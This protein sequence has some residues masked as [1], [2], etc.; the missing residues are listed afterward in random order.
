M[1]LPLSASALVMLGVGAVLVGAS[2]LVVVAVRKRKSA[3]GATR[4]PPD[5]RMA[6]AAS[7]P[8]AP[9]PDVAPPAAPQA[10]AAPA[11][12]A[13]VV[14][15]Q[16]EPVREIAEQ[17]QVP[18]PQPEP[19]VR[20]V[21]AAATPRAAEVSARVEPPREPDAGA[22]VPPPTP[23]GGV[24]VAAQRHP[25][26][27][28]G[29][30]VAAA[31]AQAFAMR[32]AASRGGT[33]RPAD[34]PEGPT[35][36][37]DPAA[38][39]DPDGRGLGA[40]AD[41][42]Q[43]SDHGPEGNGK[44][45]Q[46]W[47]VPESASDAQRPSQAVTAAPLAGGWTPPPA[48]ATG[49]G[50]EQQKD[51]PGWAAHEADALGLAAAGQVPRGDG[52]RDQE[53]ADRPQ[54]E[55][56]GAASERQDEPGWVAPAA[57]ALG[58]AAA[59]LAF[60]GDGSS[61]RAEREGATPGQDG[62]GAAGPDAAGQEP[63]GDG[64]PEQ[65]EQQDEPGWLAPPAGALGSA[66]AGHA[67]RGH[68]S[69]EQE[70]TTRGQDGAGPAALGGDG[71]PEQTD[72]GQSD[73]PQAEPEAAAPEQT[74][75]GSI[76]PAGGALGLAAAGQALHGY[77][78]PEQ[79]EQQDKPGWVAPAAGALGLAA[80]GHA[81]HGRGTPEPGDEQAISAPA[82]REEA[83]AEEA[84][85]PTPRPGTE[86]VAAEEQPLDAR[87]RLLAVLLDDPERAVGATVELESCLRELDRL[88]DAVRTGRTAL[89]DV[90][91][92]LVSAGL[93]PEQLARLAR[94]PQP[95]VDELLAAVPAEQQA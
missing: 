74:D 64:S 15:Q 52:S 14:P 88:S 1:Q 11:A 77:G 85:V 80:A 47:V 43:Q 56:E 40:A 20:P 62:A 36:A 58:L 39:T 91:Q 31:V 53:P 19:E 24:P 86:T 46:G 33:Q 57:G 89:R 35:P 84:T 66:A 51:E 95:E 13:P 82:D 55:H 71:S 5:V 26:A 23:A 63:R 93:S 72:G 37:V 60:R 67:F 6:Q 12:A 92:R 87:D 2:I 45:P 16:A 69:P 75:A 41:D 27:G 76:A 28:S 3:S 10:F 59:G 68:G 21:A 94:L 29:R 79:A 90:L 70:G 54:V 49:T 73:R 81:L 18:A 50:A 17:P 4:V 65:A 9:R 42:A 8:G 34:A 30:T 7:H 44:P 83:A 78:D 38:T 25:Q 48:A 22:N 32:A 61:E